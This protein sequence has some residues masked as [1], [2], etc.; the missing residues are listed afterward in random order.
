MFEL[1]SSRRCRFLQK[2]LE[3]WEDLV[4]PILEYV[5]VCAGVGNLG[6]YSF[7]HRVLKSSLIV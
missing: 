6:S 1:Y 4:D 3:I 2:T 5:V 7:A